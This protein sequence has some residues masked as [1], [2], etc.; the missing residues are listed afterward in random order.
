MTLS[1]HTGN[2]LVSRP[3]AIEQA[4][5]TT[6][7]Y[8]LR[9]FNAPTLTT[10]YVTIALA[11]FIAVTIAALAAIGYH[12]ATN[13]VPHRVALYVAAA[14]CVGASEIAVSAAF[15]QFR[16]IQQP[17][18]HRYLG[19]GLFS[20]GVAFM[21]LAALLYLGQAPAIYY[22]PAILT[23]QMLLCGTAVL[24]FRSI[25]YVRF[26]TEVSRGSIQGRRIVLIG[27]KKHF[28]DYLRQ[29]RF[30]G[31]GA[32]VVYC[33]IP[34]RNPDGQLCTTV[35]TIASTLVAQCRSLEADDVVLMSDEAREHELPYITS[36]FREI[37]ASVYAIP[38]RNLGFWARAHLAEVAGV[39]ALG[40]S[41]PPLSPVAL[42]IK[43]GFD[44]VVSLAALVVFSPLMLLIGI[45]I[46]LDSSG[47]VLFVQ[48][49]H[50]Y[51]NQPIRILKFRTMRVARDD[52][53]VQAKRGDPRITRLGRFLRL[54]GIDELPQLVNIL[55]GDMSIVGPRP[56]A[57]SHNEMFVPHIKMFSR[58]HN[59]KPGLTGWAQV[60]GYRGETDTI[61]K[62][63]QRIECDLYYVDN[64]SLWF[65]LQIIVLTIF[66]K[67]TYANAG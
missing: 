14:A 15:R 40:L 47:S 66:S 11:E 33:Q 18:L 23:L 35:E 29:L 67:K 36:S 56:H 50:G 51:N 21:L 49:R 43:R 61:E 55:R 62:M 39:L 45:L 5:L 34:P 31:A 20:V 28:T 27:R 17:T 6:G 25:A 22:S 37:P 52:R 12:I 19:S 2:L 57:I 59:V 32:Q 46:K 63:V 3:A 30:S 9:H 44:I 53:F 1:R 4:E 58:R 41:T 54:T 24:V 16:L 8:L 26:Q 48:T 64:W 38:R 10:T 13:D 60:N 65:D 42:A 7:S